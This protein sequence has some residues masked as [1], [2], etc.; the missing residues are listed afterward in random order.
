MN[1]SSVCHVSKTHKQSLVSVIAGCD[2]YIAH[3]NE[4][5]HAPNKDDL[6]SS[7]W[8]AFWSLSQITHMIEYI[9]LNLM[10]KQLFLR[11]ILFNWTYFK[12][13]YAINANI[14]KHFSHKLI[15][16]LSRVDRKIIVALYESF[17]LL[18]ASILSWHILFKN[19]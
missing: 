16:A 18:G 19:K 6:A 14:T 11:F 9:I 15:F 3:C 5:C 12:R 2:S 1:D 7:K 10:M 8:T 13:I 17:K 4:V